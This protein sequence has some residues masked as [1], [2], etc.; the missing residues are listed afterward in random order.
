[1]NQKIVAL[2]KVGL[3]TLVNLEEIIKYLLTRIVFII[4]GD[5]VSLLPPLCNERILVVGNG[6][7]AKEID[8]EYV[9]KKGISILCVNYFASQNEDFFKIRPKYYCAIDPF[10]YSDQNAASIENEALINA[11]NKVDWD[12][13]YICLA[14]QELP[15]LKNTHIKMISLNNLE[16]FGKYWKYTLYSKNKANFGFQNVILA[17]LYF[18][19]TGNAKTVYLC[20]VDSD[21]HRELFVDEN[22]NVYLESVHF[23]G[24]EKVNL[25]AKG[26]LKKGEYYKYAGYYYKTMEEFYYSSQYAAYKKVDV[27]NLTLNSYID[28]F[29]KISI[30]VL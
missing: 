3:A 15:A 12:M 27:Y 8:L 18:C 2:G 21:W 4:G 11:L 19:I 10:F 29:E 25:T 6:P 17:A 30:D 22:N 14:H 13:T 24:V 1:M 26:D 5:K 9:S 23:Y 28:V 7:S 20:G 16:Y